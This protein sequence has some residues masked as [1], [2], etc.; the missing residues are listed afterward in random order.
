M[1]RFRTFSLSTLALVGLLLNSVSLASAQDNLVITEFM[2]LNDRTLADEY[3]RFADWIEVYNPGDQPVNLGGWHLTDNPNNLIKW[4]FPATNIEANAFL[5][6]FAS[7]DNRAVPGA[8]LHTSFALSGGGEFLALVRPDG[9]TIVSAYAPQFPEQYPEI[10]YGY[11]RTRTI[12]SQKPP[13]RVWVPTDGALGTSWV[14]NAFDD[15]AWIAGTNGVGYETA[16]PGF[17]VYNYKASVT[18]DSLTTAQTVLATPAQRSGTNTENAPFINYFGTSSDGHDATSNRTF[19]G[20]TMG[21]D[22]DDYVVE[23]FGTITIPAAG[24]WTFVVNSDDG[25]HLDVDTFSVEYAAARGAADTFGTFTFPTA[26][27]YQI[28][29]VYYERAGGSEVELWAAPGI[30]TAWN[31]TDFH[32]VG[33]TENGGLEVSSV[34]I[35]GGYQSGGGYRGDIRTD[36]QSLMQSNQVSA[37]V[38]I[39]F[40]VTNAVALESLLL[41]VKYDD[42][43]VAYLNGVEVAR[44]NAPNVPRLGYPRD[45]CPLWFEIRIDQHFVLPRRFAGRRQSTGPPRVE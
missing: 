38:R 10:S 16:V 3:G 39:P 35:A 13:A 37:Y 25:F 27:L 5:V 31:A 1:K 45:Q 17:A 26:G 11:G 18:V 15:G 21:T 30:Q 4:T 32:L 6:V 42:G 19:P 9:T 24:D 34:P 20:L 28:H 40:A 12:L 7:G 14:S 36:V 2:A 8:P 29:L 33:D 22:I 43:F 41:K 23:A 44:R